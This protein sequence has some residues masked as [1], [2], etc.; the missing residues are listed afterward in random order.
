[1]LAKDD[2]TK[3]FSDSASFY[4]RPG[5]YNMTMASFESASL[6]GYYLAMNGRYSL[7]V[8]FQVFLST[9]LML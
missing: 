3:A 1:M 9:H 5:L 2:G 8:C 7:V 6:S 4:Q